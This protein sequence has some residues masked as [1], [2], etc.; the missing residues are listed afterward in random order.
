VSARYAQWDAERRAGRGRTGYA[1]Q[2]RMRA[3]SRE[4][5]HAHPLPVPSFENKKYLDIEITDNYYELIY[6]ISCLY[7][8]FKVNYR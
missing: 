4:G 2:K 1:A 5:P 7:I 8:G 6:Y 3:R